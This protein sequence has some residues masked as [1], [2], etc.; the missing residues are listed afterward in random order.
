MNVAL[1]QLII[2]NRVLPKGTEISDADMDLIRSKY[3]H[4]LA[5]IL[6]T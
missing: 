6:T 4:F 5:Y 1:S 2:A 3:P